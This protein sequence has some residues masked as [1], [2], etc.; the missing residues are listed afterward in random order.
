MTRKAP[1]QLASDPRPSFS[2]ACLKFGAKNI[3]L[4]W[5]LEDVQGEGIGK[6]FLDVAGWIQT[7]LIT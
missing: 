2:T 1:L 7:E 3:C 5:F 6:T 4:T